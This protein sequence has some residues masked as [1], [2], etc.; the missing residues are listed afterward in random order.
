MM[1][2]VNQHKLQIIVMTLINKHNQVLSETGE[3]SNSGVVTIIA[4]LLL[5]VSLLLTFKNLK[6][7]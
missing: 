2:I 6:I 5:T 7:K 4:L 3:Q 1:L